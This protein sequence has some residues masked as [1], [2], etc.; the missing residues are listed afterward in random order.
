MEAVGYQKMGV[1]NPIK[2]ALMDTILNGAPE[3]SASTIIE[4]YEQWL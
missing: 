2:E 1:K 3:D 4:L